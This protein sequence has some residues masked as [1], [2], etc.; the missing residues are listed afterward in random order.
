MHRDAVHRDAVRR[1]L[2]R[3]SANVTARFGHRDHGAGER[4]KDHFGNMTTDFGDR[5][6]RQPAP[7]LIVHPDRGS[8]Y[9]SAMHAIPCRSSACAS[10]CA[11]CLDG[12]P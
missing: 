8:Q 6:R 12:A 2:V 11:R 5:D 4:R 9:A 1:V 10:R 7:R 3:I